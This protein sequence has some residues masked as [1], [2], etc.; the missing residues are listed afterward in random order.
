[1]PEA[2]MS[3]SFTRALAAVA[4][5]GLVLT[6]CA[7]Q[8]GPGGSRS[9]GDENPRS[10]GPKILTIALQ[11]EYDTAVEGEGEYLLRDGSC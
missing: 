6:A 2:T 3:S 9:A 1:M 11:R 10:A 5:L 8:S 4:A 7:P